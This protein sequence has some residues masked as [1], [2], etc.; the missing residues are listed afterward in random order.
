MTFLP[1][2]VKCVIAKSAGSV[3]PEPVG[4]VINTCSP[5]RMPSIAYFWKVDKGNGY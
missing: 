4:A 3:L 5:F 1:R 2:E